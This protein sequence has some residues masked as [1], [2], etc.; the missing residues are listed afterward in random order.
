M[1]HPLLFLTAASVLI[2]VAVGCIPPPGYERGRQP[3][4]EDRREERREN[5]HDRDKDDR[6][7][8]MAG[9]QP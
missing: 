8:Q 5:R 7:G 3:R 4:R 1:K 6:H 2:G 9:L